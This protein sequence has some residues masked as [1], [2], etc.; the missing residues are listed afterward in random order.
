D[1]C[2]ARVAHRVEDQVVANGDG[3]AQA[4][5]RGVGLLPRLGVASTRLE[6]AHDRRA[7]LRLHDHHA[8]AT[9]TYP[10]EGF[11]LVERI[12][13]ADDARPAAGGVHDDVRQARLAPAALLGKL[14][15]HRLLAFLAVRLAQRG[16]VEPAVPRG[17][18]A[19]QPTGVIDEPVDQHHLGTVRLGFDPV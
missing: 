19:D 7:A 4:S 2:A 3:D 9:G 1:R 14:D 8:W 11:E 17:E 15:A 18:L 10:A 6:R 5:G 13:H 16:Q 12:A